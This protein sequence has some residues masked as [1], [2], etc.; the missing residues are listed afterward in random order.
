MPGKFVGVVTLLI[1][2][3]VAALGQGKGKPDKELIQ[4]NWVW[5]AA[6]AQSDA[7]PVVLVERIVINGDQL[8]FHYKME[9]DRFRSPTTFKIDS[10]AIP[11]QIEFTPTQGPNQG[12]T[13]VG[14]YE[15]KEGT[16]RIAYRGPGSPRPKRFH[17]ERL[18]GLTEDVSLI[19]LKRSP[20]L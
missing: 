2:S 20:N 6:Y 12:K 13:Y 1:L 10:E 4:G 16:L 18:P 17:N 11:K 19:Y 5:D 15:I 9:A 14:I 3:T 7:T 8:T